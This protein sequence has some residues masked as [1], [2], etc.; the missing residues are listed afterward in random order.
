M[1]GVPSGVSSSASGGSG[2]SASGTL[3]SAR[4]KNVVN[5]DTLVLVPPKST[6]VPVPERMLTLQYVRGELF[7]AREFLRQLVV[8]KEIK[9]KVLFKLPSGKEFGDVQ[10][11]IF[12]SLIQYLVERGY[13][14]L[15]ENLRPDSDQEEAFI[16]DL[17]ALQEK[18]QKLQLGVWA[19]DF[20][21]PQAVELSDLL[22]QQS[23]LTPLET[24]V[25]RVISGDRIIGRVLVSSHSYV[26][27]PMILAGLKCPR[28]DDLGPTQKVA[29]E[30]KKYVEDHLVSRTNV[31]IRVVGENQ[32]GVPLVIVEHPSGNSIHEKLLE[33]G[34]AE[35][36]DWQS[37]LLG[38]TLMSGLRKAELKAKGLAKGLYATTKL[39]ATSGP[40][41]AAKV[42]GKSIRPGVTVDVNVS[43]VINADTVNVTLPSGEEIT[44]Q[45]ASI[46]APKPNDTTVTQNALQQAA[47][48]QMAKEF[49][50]LAAIG[51]TASMY[52]D[53][54][55]DA[56]KDLNLDLRFLVSLKI[57]GSDL[58]ERLVTRGFATVI[59][60]NKQTSHERS[61]NWDRLIELEEAQ[62]KEAKNGV[63]FAGDISKILTIG[64]RVVN[65]SENLTKAKTF[66]NGFQKKGRILGFYVEFVSSVNRVKLYSPR[67]GTKLTLVLGG[68]SNDRSND[69]G[70]KYMNS[71]YLQRNVEF[72]IYDMDKIGGFIGNL[73]ASEQAP[74]PVQVELLKEGLCAVHDFAASHNPYESDLASAERAAQKEQKGIWVGY[75]EAAEKKKQESLANE[76]NQL[77]LEAAKPKF[78]D[79][80]V[81]DIDPSQTITFHMLDP[82]TAAKKASFKKSFN[83]FHAQG[84][85]ASTSSVDL[86]V[87]LTKVPKKN[88]LVS[89]KFAENGKFYRARVVNYDKTTKKVE[90]KHVDFGNTDHVSLALLRA[91]PKQFSVDTIPSFAHTCRLQGVRLPPAQP[92]DYLSEALYLLEDLT[93]D[94]KLVISGLP[95]RIPGIEYS[96]V[97]YDSEQSLT[98][99]EY[100]I[101][102]QMVS[103]G[104]GIVD[105]KNGP[106]EYV[107]KLLAVQRTAMSSRLGCWEF[108]DIRED[109][110]QRF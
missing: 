87:N 73:Y 23:V 100:T 98:D 107:E 46:R 20:E 60:H 76:I 34:L 92:K 85:S 16:D 66:F 86:P 38:A 39:P 42:S 97:L 65:A 56:N 27:T 11:P 28:T 54:Y 50:R 88:D 71:R 51:K 95:S 59:K 45:L 74:K 99:P 3:L 8:G 82:Q 24:V 15:K 63:F 83:D 64:T 81:V 89:A 94:K 105:E 53:G 2:A 106:K 104:Y 40:T 26:L 36:V 67:E 84:P 78:F 96:A 7:L 43:K 17:R 47:L 75:D 68:L 108:G 22:V 41:A 55:R 110:E 77:N 91:L 14:K 57:D 18:A 13:V 103:E 90:V 31:A 25:E 29:F 93:F 109:E 9:F 61:M 30:A 32:G 35:I 70:L 1:S 37:S 102:N 58:A 12:S 19:D 79:I 48:V 49:T 52:V 80:E 33:N 101:N 6:Q 21:E 44:V 5:G 62:K 4:V 72:D 69:S 10:A